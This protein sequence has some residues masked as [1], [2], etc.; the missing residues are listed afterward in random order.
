VQMVWLPYLRVGLVSSDYEG[1]G[2]LVDDTKMGCRLGLGE[3]ED[4][5]DHEVGFQC[6]VCKLR[7]FLGRIYFLSQ[8]C[9]GERGWGCKLV[10]DD[11]R[12]TNLS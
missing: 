1:E 3:G 9:G 4:F 5:L 8:E 6:W 10:Q 11:F 7:D 12:R 2:K